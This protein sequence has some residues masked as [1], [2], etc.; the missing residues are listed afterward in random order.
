MTLQL[1][2]CNT[3]REF[4]SECLKVKQQKNPRYSLRK[5]ARDLN[6]SPST[7]CEVLKGK[8]NLSETSTLK[9]I[10]KLKLKAKEADYFNQ[11]S[12]MER[13]RN[14]ELKILIQ[15]QIGQKHKKRNI[16][17][18]ST[19]NFKTISEWHHSA[20]IAACDMDEKMTPQKLARLLNVPG[21]E[22]YQA[23]E[24]MERLGILK[25]EITGEIHPLEN[26]VMIQTEAP[27]EALQKYTK[28]MLQ[29]AADNASEQGNDEKIYGTE[30]F[31]FDDKDLP[32][33]R[34]LT[35][36]YFDNILKIA[37]KSKT[38]KRVYHASVQIFR[39]SQKI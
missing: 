21:H 5:F 39:L 19:D 9:I 26:D 22:I 27:N 23:I 28:Q 31:A 1:L 14:P 4:L 25:Q 20:I 18:L 17:D 34:D 6:F 10:T 16:V 13:C 11:L 30:T 15:D 33:L 32:K 12:S 38:K 36:E 2:E 3:S 37:K 24:R 35:E 29:K 7:L 8:K